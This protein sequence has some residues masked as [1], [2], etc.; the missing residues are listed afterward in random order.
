MKKNPNKSNL[1]KT[2]AMRILD[3]NGIEYGWSE[4]DYDESDL[5]GTH[6]ADLLGVPREAC[7]QGL[8]AFSGAERRFEYKGQV[9]GVTII[10]D[11]AHHPTEIKA[12]LKA[13]GDYPHKEIWCVFQPH[14]YTRTK[15]LLPQFAEALSIADKVVLAD[16]YAARELDIY[17][18]SSRD[19]Q[20]EITKLGTDCLY[21]PSFEEIENYLR[22]NVSDGDLVIT[23]GAGNI[24]QVGEAL[25][26]EETT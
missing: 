11:Y 17:G 6:A 22:D 2:N 23:M 14:T 12:T 7:I 25:T 3:Q 9:G 10:D 19:L 4:Y 24:V 18:I 15:A 5:S 8:R 20:E 13:A 1:N 16:I 26:S 21:F